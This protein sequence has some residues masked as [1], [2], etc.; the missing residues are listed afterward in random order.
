LLFPLLTFAVYHS[1][2][3]VLYDSGFLGG[4]ETPF[5]RIRL[6]K[7]STIVNNEQERYIDHWYARKRV[8][9]ECFFGR[10]TKVFRLFTKP[11]LF[12]MNYLSID[13]D[14]VIMLT[15]EHILSR[16]LGDDDSSFWRQWV[17]SNHRTVAER[18]AKKK[19]SN[20]SYRMRIRAIVEQESQG[21]D[22]DEEMQAGAPPA[23]RFRHSF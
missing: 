14:N 17:S 4:E 11:Y 2:W 5:T 16:V 20:A 6:R 13:V 18:R 21:M 8:Q 7:P 3:A 15:N 12:D 1:Y 10:M 19:A 9:I 23:R 22:I